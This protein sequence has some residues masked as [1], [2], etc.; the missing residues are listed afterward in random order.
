MTVHDSTLVF[1]L[2]HLNIQNRLQRPLRLRVQLRMGVRL[3][4]VESSTT[5]LYGS[6]GSVNANKYT[7]CHAYCLN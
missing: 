7:I 4:S 2:A 1:S 3:H 6:N 5:T